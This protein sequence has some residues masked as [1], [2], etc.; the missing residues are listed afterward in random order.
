MSQIR[1]HVFPVFS[2]QHSLCIHALYAVHLHS[3]GLVT[4]SNISHSLNHCLFIFKMPSFIFTTAVLALASTILASPQYGYENMVNKRRVT[5]FYPTGTAALHTGIGTGKIL[6]PTAGLKYTNDT[7]AGP[8]HTTKKSKS[9]FS[10]SYISYE[11]T[12]T[13]Y[14][15]AAEDVD[16]ASPTSYTKTTTLFSNVYVDPVAKGTTTSIPTAKALPVMDASATSTATSGD[17]GEDCDD[18][19]TSTSA[20]TLSTAIQTSY[21]GKV[22]HYSTSS[23]TPAG[24]VKP[25]ML[26]TLGWKG[27]WN[28]T[29]TGSSS[30]YPTG[31]GKP[32]GTRYPIR[33]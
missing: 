11:S 31:T 1:T 16:C 29:V 10:S 28:G 4:H 2:S 25:S 24:P 19:P 21:S 13:I 17:E 26:P 6:Y 20:T 15:S 32:H 14:I 12:T 30:L 3:F 8:K 7:S 18:Y 5:G 27:S 33:Y 22:H 23:S 9:S